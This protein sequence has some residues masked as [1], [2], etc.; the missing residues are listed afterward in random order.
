M[1]SYLVDKLRRCTTL[2]AWAQVSISPDEAKTLLALID[3]NRP[4]PAPAPTRCADCGR[5]GRNLEAVPEGDGTVLLGPTC[6]RRRIDAGQVRQALP[7][8]GDR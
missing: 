5:T 1:S 4:Q 6:K 3:R 8:G 2:P 7:I